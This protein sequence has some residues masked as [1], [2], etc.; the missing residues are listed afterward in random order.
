VERVEIFLSLDK[1]GL[2]LGFVSPSNLRPPE[3]VGYE[4]LCWKWNSDILQLLEFMIDII[5]III[6]INSI[7]FKESHSSSCDN[8]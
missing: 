3:K 7:Q 8:Y 4:A 2:R 6:I 1:F 5:I